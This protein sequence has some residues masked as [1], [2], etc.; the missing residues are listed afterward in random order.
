[1]PDR[2]SQ[3]RHV[4]VIPAAGA[5][6]RVGAPLPKQYLRLGARTMLEWSVDA[7][8]AVPWIE[9]VLVVVAPDDRRAD[10][11]VDG[12]TRVEV[13]PQGGATRRDSVL[14]GLNALA[15][16]VD[17]QD[18]VLVH[19]AAR[20]ALDVATLERLRSAL[21]TSPV[22]GLLALPVGD[23]VKRATPDR[24]ASAATLDREGLWAA[25]TPQM[26]RLG[27]LRDA[28]AAHADVT[29]EASALERAGHAPLLVEGAR[30]NFKV[31][32]A[33]DVELMRLVL[34]ARGGDAKEP[35]KTEG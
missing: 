7:L 26:F 17:S 27:L 19:D 29:D 1:M 28:L 12:R 35:R 20:P 24:S 11:L 15:R 25:Q 13:L 30:S 32:G 4:A 18:W 9:R 10:A 21:A 6:T 23:T 31:T 8:L 14:A 22:G 33:D 34:A 2:S 16:D 5:G 3:P